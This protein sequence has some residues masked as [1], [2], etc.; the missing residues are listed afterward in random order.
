MLLL[1]S[2][3]LSVFLSKWQHSSDRNTPSFLVAL[4]GTSIISQVEMGL[5]S[6]VAPGGPP[7]VCG[8]AI[9]VLQQTQSQSS[10]LQAAMKIFN[11]GASAGLLLYS[12][13]GG[14]F[15]L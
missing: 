3:K 5:K 11:S 4:D 9:G 14:R 7:C 10:S 2:F 13:Q 1:H 15:N 12:N 6:V 8:G